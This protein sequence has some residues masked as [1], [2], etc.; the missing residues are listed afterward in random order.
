MTKQETPT[1]AIKKIDWAEQFM[2]QHLQAFRCSYCHDAMVSAEN[3]SVVCKKGHRFN[4]SKKGI[5]HLMKQNA[6][7]GSDARGNLTAS[8]GE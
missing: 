5:L 4:I 2:N 3:H 8:F 1:E 6:N 7:T